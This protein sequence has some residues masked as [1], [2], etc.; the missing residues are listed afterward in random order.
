[1]LL[2]NVRQIDSKK[3]LE[4]FRLT[5]LVESNKRY[6]QKPQKWRVAVTGSPHRRRRLMRQAT[7]R[8]QVDKYN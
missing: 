2:I 3:P 1:M 5:K 4:Y 7:P 6:L 8:Q